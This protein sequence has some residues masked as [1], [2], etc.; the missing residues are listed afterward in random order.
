MAHLGSEPA[1]MD[2]GEGSGTFQPGRVWNRMTLPSISCPQNF[3][4]VRS[5]NRTFAMTLVLVG[6]VALS[7]PPNIL[8]QQSAGAAEIIGQIRS[9]P[10]TVTATSAPAPEGTESPQSCCAPFRGMTITD[11]IV[12]RTPPAGDP[13]PCFSCVPGADP[14]HIAVPF[15]EAIAF[16]GGPWSTVVTAHSQI[17]G[18]CTFGFVWFSVPFNG[19]VA[20]NSLN[21]VDCGANN[22]WLINFFNNT[23]PNVPGDA[24][25][26]GFVQAADG[27]V[28]TSFE[29]FV[30][31]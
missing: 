16:V 13:V 4:E 25:A 3:M 2:A 1:P 19:I 9:N 22:V 27:T 28:S 17:P 29:Q 26:V 8:A 20:G 7:F 11:V 6:L 18:P 30:I 21:E 23:V 15:P 24:I 12:S 14:F 5:M 10:E 31:Q